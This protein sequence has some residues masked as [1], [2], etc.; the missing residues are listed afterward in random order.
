MPRFD[1]VI[2]VTE[3]DFARLRPGQT[4]KLATDAYPGEA[5]TGA[6]ARISPV[7]SEATLW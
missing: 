2:Q 7:F 3:R 1:A 4:A 6:I 5:F